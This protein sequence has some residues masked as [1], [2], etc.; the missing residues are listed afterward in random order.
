MADPGLNRQ[1]NKGWIR[2]LPTVLRDKVAGRDYLQNV[3]SNT[4]W[5][6]ADNVLRMGVGLLVGIWVA[7]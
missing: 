1:Y 2:F 5:Q 4:G 6:F 3:I 7:R